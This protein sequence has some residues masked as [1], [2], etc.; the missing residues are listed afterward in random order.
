[1]AERVT[2][3]GGR[4]RRELLVTGALVACSTA[5]CLRLDESS[6]PTPGGAASTDSPGDG[7]D[8]PTSP[9]GQPT[10]TPTTTEA[11]PTETGGATPEPAVSPPTTID[12]RWTQ[13]QV[14]AA[15]T[16]HHPSAV[17]PKA[18]PHELWVATVDGEFGH[19]SATLGD[20]I[21]YTKTN[22][23]ASVHAFDA[24]S[25][26]QR[27]ATEVG[28]L[29]GG[30][31]PTLAEGQLYIGTKSGRLVALD[32]ED[33]R[34]RWF[35]DANPGP[36]YFGIMGSVTVAGGAL[37]F[38]DDS[39][40]V[41]SLDAAGNERWQFET[42]GSIGR[43]TPAVVDGT[44]Y[45]G[46]M[47]GHLYALDAAAG[48]QQWRRSLGDAV[49]ASPTVRDG[50]VYVGA[51]STTDGEG[52]LTRADGDDIERERETKGTLYSLATGDGST[53][54]STALPK[55]IASSVAV[56]GGRVFGGPWNGPLYAFDAASG[57]QQW[58]YPVDSI[59][60]GPPAVADGVVYLASDR[61]YAIDAATGRGRWT[62]ET[63]NG[64]DTT[65]VVSDGVVYAGDHDGKL[66]AVYGDTSG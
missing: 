24:L 38:G 46:S 43:S 53:Q 4:T 9:S 52:P 30:A 35:Y 15:N 66:Y 28:N 25:G 33:G 29:R 10:E 31:S 2:D 57:D 56:A 65:P 1:M 11:G 60:E 23:T 47:D 37:Y 55:L 16:G 54:W 26:D 62:F 64:M 18:D 5:G 50:S 17:G 59:Q 7:A 34:R 6:S 8:Q 32:A 63:S 51:I 45:V 20:G 48:E 40:I 58:F 3:D 14:D 39:G 44:V 42:G 12:G 21:L 49:F 19:D 41:Y 61:L 22:Q 27:W 36:N 13:Y